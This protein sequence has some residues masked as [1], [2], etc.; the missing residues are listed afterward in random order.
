MILVAVY[1]R[2]KNDKM[3]LKV[4]PGRSLIITPNMAGF[5]IAQ[6]PDVAKRLVKTVATVYCNVSALKLEQNCFASIN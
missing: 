4:N 1:V 3:K 6:S 5:F 2:E